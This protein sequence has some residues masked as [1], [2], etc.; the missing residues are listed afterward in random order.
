MY[1]HLTLLHEVK[2][3]AGRISVYGED[4]S[5]S[6]GWEKARQMIGLCPQQSVLF[7]L[8]TVEETLAYYIA[9]KQHSHDPPPA[10][11]DT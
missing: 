4:V 5:T 11:V 6:E 2:P 9:L 7:P 10:K 8:L 1:S 3:T